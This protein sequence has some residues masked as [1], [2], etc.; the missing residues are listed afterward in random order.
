MSAVCE[1]YGIRLDAENTFRRYLYLNLNQH[2][3]T[4]MSYCDPMTTDIT[5]LT[6]VLKTLPSAHK[7]KM[8]IVNSGQHDVIAS[9]HDQQCVCKPGVTEWEFDLVKPFDQRLTVEFHFKFDQTYQPEWAQ[10]DSNDYYSKNGL[11]IEHIQVD[12]RD[13]TFWGFNQITQ[14]QLF[15]IT[16]L[17]IDYDL[18]KNQR[19]VVHNTTLSWQIPENIGLQAWLLKTLN[20][21]DYQE[22]SHVDRRLCDE[23]VL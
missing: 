23:L 11:Y 15:D 2:R 12:H 6:A 22:R 4:I 8:S 14:Q 7:I 3:E 5:D 20:P 9:M 17:P 13:I 1:H 10:Y 21:A 16:D 19:C 18:H